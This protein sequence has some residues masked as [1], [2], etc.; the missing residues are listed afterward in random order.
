M[1]LKFDRWPRKIIGHLCYTISDFVHNFKSI[2]EFKLKLQFRKC[3]IQVK[4]GVFL[5]R[6]TSSFVHYFKCISEVNWSYSPETLN[7]GKKKSACFVRCDLK[8]WQMTLNNNNKKN[9]NRAS[10]L[11]NIK[12]CAWFPRGWGVG[13]G[14]HKLSYGGG[15]GG[16]GGGGGLYMV[17]FERPISLK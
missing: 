11:S 7:S 12:F 17:D 6:V 9:I 3:P 5:S 15:W 13:Q 1:T 4:I 2:S 16:G 14:S 8:I 10:L